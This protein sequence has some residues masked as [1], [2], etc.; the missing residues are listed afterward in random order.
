MTKKKA[1]IFT[2]IFSIFTICI[3]T[4][5]MWIKPYDGDVS[6]FHA[7]SPFIAG[8]WLADLIDKFYQ[9]LIKKCK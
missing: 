5:L 1:K 8:L 4:V 6:L 2:I 9:R 3:T 7:I